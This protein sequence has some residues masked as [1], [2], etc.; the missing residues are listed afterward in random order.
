VGPRAGL[1][2]AEEQNVRDLPRLQSRIIQGAAVYHS[3][4]QVRASTMLLL[5]IVGSCEGRNWDWAPT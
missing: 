5:L 4:L 1:E 2:G 3:G